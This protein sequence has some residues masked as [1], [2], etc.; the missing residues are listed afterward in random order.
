M[1]IR[2]LASSICNRSSYCRP[3]QLRNTPL[4]IDG[5]NL[6]FSLH[7]KANLHCIFGGEYPEY[8]AIVENFF[9]ILRKVG[10]EPVLIFDGQLHKI[11]AQSAV[12]P[13]RKRKLDR[14]MSLFHGLTREEDEEFA[15]LFLEDILKRVA[16]KQNV[17]MHQAYGDLN[18]LVVSMA[19]DLKC[20]ALSRNSDF[21]ILR[22]QFGFIY[23]ESLILPPLGD[24]NCGR[25]LKS[26]YLDCSIF[27]FDD[28]YQKELSQV[29]LDVLPLFG[30]L[31]GKNFLCCE[32]LDNLIAGLITAEYKKG[33]YRSRP[34]TVS[35]HLTPRLVKAFE[36]F[37]N[38]NRQTIVDEI[39][40]AMFGGRDR[41]AVN[42]SFCE[43]CGDIM[44]TK[45]Q[46][47]GFIYK[48]CQF[49][50]THT[51]EEWR[52]DL[53]L[54]AKNS[55]PEWCLEAHEK[56]C[57]PPHLMQLIQSNKILLWVVVEDF[58][59]PSVFDCCLWLRLI[60]YKCCMNRRA[61][62]FAKTFTITEFSRDS[63]GEM[64]GKQ[65][66]IDRNLDLHG[67]PFL[68]DFCRS[69]SR[70]NISWIN[71]ALNIDR[72][73][74]DCFKNTPFHLRGFL[75]SL[76]LWHKF[77]T[78]P[79]DK[80]LYA[81]IICSYG[82][83]SKNCC[84]SKWWRDSKFCVEDDRDRRKIVNAIFDF[85]QP[86]NVQQISDEE[87]L[88]NAVH[89]FNEWQAIVQGLEWL[90]AVTCQPFGRQMIKIEDFFCGSI[91]YNLTAQSNDDYREK[92]RHSKKVSLEKVLESPKI[93]KCY[94]NYESSVMSFIYPV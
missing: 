82:L 23:F 76:K 18:P 11:L 73:T 42:A 54:S 67:W 16:N 69:S 12:M 3:F 45:A 20:P 35:G 2:G 48:A 65:I 31:F 52:R 34:S 80:C 9:R 25:N 94:R 78:K 87:S 57:F 33:D 62:K 70:Q 30:V 90:N 47:V 79:K 17:E 13:Y 71:R 1:G 92:D 81:I 10:V 85:E 4:V 58:S 5:T 15:S 21:F 19:N 84:S 27:H 8:A 32:H 89:S 72:S 26:S 6:V 50:E 83:L 68:D 37:K 43:K 93:V 49:Y 64:S 7:R 77:T 51:G 22:T 63:N 29:D 41:K 24:E 56:L 59:S 88:R 86:A 53:E 39:T 75:L 36:F 55:A 61:T 40:T 14:T 28:Y 44:S 46:F 38:K 91:C 60:V 74:I 66:T